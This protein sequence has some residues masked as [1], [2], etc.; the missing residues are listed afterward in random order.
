MAEGRP[1]RFLI[2]D[3]GSQFRSAFGRSCKR[4]RITHIR[5][6]VGVWQLNAKVERFF[7]TL[8]TWQRRTWMAPSQRSILRRLDAFSEWY[9]EH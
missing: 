3:H 9:N 4:Y 5:G 7:R 6:S 2:S 8:K 1:P